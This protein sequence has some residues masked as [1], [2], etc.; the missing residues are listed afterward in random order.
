[1]E[2]LNENLNGTQ[3]TEVNQEAT[4]STNEGETQPKTF[5]EEEVQKMLQ[6][7]ADKRV[8]QA[9]EKS[10]A[11]WE[12]EYQA[13]LE[14]EK[15]QAEKLAQLT[16][17]E[18]YEAKLKEEREQ[19]ESERKAFE[20]EKMQNVTIKELSSRSLPVEFAEYLVAD[21]AETVKANIETFNAKWTDAITKAVDDRLK[22]HTPKA[23]N[24]LQT[25]MT[26]KE[27]HNLPSKER[28]KLY[29]E[30]PEMYK[31]FL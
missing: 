7:E 31:E 27:F 14:A 20:K 13:K 8:S 15:S 26:K 24:T 16:E 5:T 3:E 21:N 30:N 23:S 28:M 22:G 10:K 25:T 18:R 29:T 6:S 19:F 17:A 9:L 2:Q 12:S 1:M 11:K 4:N